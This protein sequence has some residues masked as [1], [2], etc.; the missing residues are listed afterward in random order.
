MFT[1]KLDSKLYMKLKRKLGERIQKPL[2]LLT[3]GIDQALHTCQ[4]SLKKK[5]SS[6]PSQLSYKIYNLLVDIVSRWGQIKIQQE[7][8]LPPRGAIDHCI[9]LLL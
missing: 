9:L 4:V 5:K 7:R 6:N 2:V 8:R 1:S 3:E